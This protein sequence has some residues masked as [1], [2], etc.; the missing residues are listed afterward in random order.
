MEKVIKWYTSIEAVSYLAT[1]GY[2]T[3]LTFLKSYINN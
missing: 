2:L 1:I 3:P